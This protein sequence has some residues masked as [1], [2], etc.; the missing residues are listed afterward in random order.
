MA[1]ELKKSDI[2]AGRLGVA[3]YTTRNDAHDRYKHRRDAA[4]ETTT[5]SPRWLM[6]GR[7]DTDAHGSHAMPIS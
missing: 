2:F 4:R 6:R 5:Y 7:K 3:A 1:V